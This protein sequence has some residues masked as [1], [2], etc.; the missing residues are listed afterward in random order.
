LAGFGRAELAVRL[1]R[2]AARLGP[3]LIHELVLLVK[4]QMCEAH[5]ACDCHSRCAD[6]RRP[7]APMLRHSQQL[8]LPCRTA[9][10]IGNASCR[11]TWSQWRTVT[12]DMSTLRQLTAREIAER[13]TPTLECSQAIQTDAE[14]IICM[15][16]HA[17]Q[18]PSRFCAP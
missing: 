5:R 18:L 4:L 6:R 11:Y 10:R 7:L 8:L 16:R 3:T 13:R 14:R 17:R 15:H 2:T 9:Y 12:I 1:L